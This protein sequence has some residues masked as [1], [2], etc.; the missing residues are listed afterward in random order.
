MAFFVDSLLENLLL[1]KEALLRKD[2]KDPLGNPGKDGSQ[3]DPAVSGKSRIRQ[4]TLLP[5]P[6][7]EPWSDLLNQAA[8]E[9]HGLGSPGQPMDAGGELGQVGRRIEGAV[10]DEAVRFIALLVGL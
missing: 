4:E 6:C 1:L 7:V 5:I 2:N 10:H 3:F 9:A 8:H